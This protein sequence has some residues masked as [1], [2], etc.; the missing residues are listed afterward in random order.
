MNKYKTKD[1]QKK[2]ME[3]W[4]FWMSSSNNTRIEP[5][6]TRNLI[7]WNWFDTKL[8]QPNHNL[9]DIS[10]THETILLQSKSTFRALDTVAQT[11]LPLP[12]FTF[13]THTVKYPFTHNMLFKPYPLSILFSFTFFQ[14][15]LISLILI[16][17]WVELIKKPSFLHILLTLT[18]THSTIKIQIT[19]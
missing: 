2:C 7:F 16:K 1:L 18:H 9:F 11:T 4:Y 3:S 19:Y 6:L 8:D 13:N 10:K 5:F 17:I 12:H 15:N 14:T